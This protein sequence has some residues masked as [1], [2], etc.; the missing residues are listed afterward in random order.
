MPQFNKTLQRCA[1]WLVTN[2]RAQ[3]NTSANYRERHPATFNPDRLAIARGKSG[4]TITAIA[5]GIF[6]FLF[7]LVRTKRSAAADAAITLRLQKQDHPVLDQ[8]LKLVS[9]PGF[10]P[11]SRILPPAFSAILWFIGFRLEAIFQ[12]LAWGTGGVSFT[13]KRIMRR[14]RPTG[15]DTAIRV[16]VANIGGSSFPSGHVLNYM[17]V[18]GF[19]NYL[20]FTWIRPAIIRRTIVSLLTALLT[21]VGPSR[22]YLGHHWFTDVMASYCLGIAYLIGLT[23]VYRQVRRWLSQVA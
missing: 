8:T 2:P 11:Q 19:L 21:S 23:S 9:W 4:V 22:V 3:S 5:L 20:A 7:V 6:A 1:I 16:V 14:P 15:G 10:P 17:G 12:L 13:V 18:Y